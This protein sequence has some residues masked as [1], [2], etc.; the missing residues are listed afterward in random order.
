VNII[1][2]IFICLF[3]LPPP[4]SL[5]CNF[6]NV[7]SLS[8]ETIPRMNHHSLN[9]IQWLLNSEKFSC[10]SFKTY[11]S[12]KILEVTCFKTLLYWRKHVISHRIGTQNLV[13]YS[14]TINF[15]SE[16]VV[17]HKQTV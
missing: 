4:L 8:H 12:Q 14:K 16:S 11:A 6:M 13:H 5:I 9:R 15:T 3:V 2:M 7:R 10:G 1:L 17:Y